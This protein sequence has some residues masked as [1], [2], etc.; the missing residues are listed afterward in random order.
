MIAMRFW[1]APSLRLTSFLLTHV[2]RDILL[3]LCDHRGGAE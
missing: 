3:K 1:P 2:K